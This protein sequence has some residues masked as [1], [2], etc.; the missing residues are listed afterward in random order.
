MR[1]IGGGGGGGGGLGYQEI[2]SKFQVGS[3]TAFEKVNTG[4]AG[5]DENLFMLE[6][7]LWS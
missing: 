6:I 3:S 2:G 4:T 7:Y 1:G 5:T